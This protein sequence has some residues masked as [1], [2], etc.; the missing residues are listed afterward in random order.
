[1]SRLKHCVFDATDVG[2][3]KVCM[4]LARATARTLRT[5]V[6][7]PVKEGRWPDDSDPSVFDD[8]HPDFPELTSVTLVLY[9]SL[10]PTWFAFFQHLLTSRSEHIRD[11]SICDYYLLTLKTLFPNP[12]AWSA[13]KEL[14]ITMEKTGISLVDLPHAPSLRKLTL[15]TGVTTEIPDSIPEHLFPNLAYLACPYQLLPLFLPANAR[16]QRPIRTVRL[17]RA[18]FDPNG[19]AKDSF[20]PA[21]IPDWDDVRVALASLPRSAG[22]VVNLA[23]YCEWFDA[24]TFPSEIVDNVKTLE[25]LV[26]VLHYDPEDAEH[27]LHFGE[28]LFAHMPRLHSFYLSDAPIKAGDVMCTFD[29]ALR[30]SR[31]E[32]WLTEWARHTS[33]LTEVA[34]T[35]ERGWR[36]LE[37]G[38]TI[39]WY[40]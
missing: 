6:F 31:E 16:K 25:Q 19:E 1:M 21:H 4:A 15:D 11:L 20:T 35:T 18:Y 36:R 37:D 39:G 24:E 5:I 9:D 22:P 33:A 32:R 12:G 14:T 7:F 28:R 13:L 29:F 2:T 10:P 40:F 27:L 3:P 26:I 38:W 30:N 17:N 34:L 8:F 23:F